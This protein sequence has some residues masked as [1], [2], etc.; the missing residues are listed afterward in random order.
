MK[1]HLLAAAFATLLAG[2]AL[3]VETLVD[4]TEFRVRTAGGQIEKVS[5][6]DLQIGEVRNLNTEAG[7]PIVVGRHETGY[8][9]DVA[10]ERIEV[11]APEVGDIEQHLVHAGD[12]DHGDDGR[13]RKIVRVHKDVQE[14]AGDQAQQKRKVVVVKH[15]HEGEGDEDLEVLIDGDGLADGGIPEGKRVVVLRKLEKHQT[16]Q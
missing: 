8:V 6:A 11:D 10:G 13:V 16:A 4:T 5:V 15:A 3:A 1:L 12:D 14:G 2:S 7:T 9:I